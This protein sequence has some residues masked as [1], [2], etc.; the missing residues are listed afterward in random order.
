M[1]FKS[2]TMK[3]VA[4]KFLSEAAFTD[5]WRREFT[6]KEGFL[7]SSS[8][9]RPTRTSPTTRARGVHRNAA[10]AKFAPIIP[11]WEEMADTTAGALQQIYLG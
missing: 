5:K 9:W 8:R 7:P 6:L 2:S 3:D 11:N 10:H 4:W 1:I